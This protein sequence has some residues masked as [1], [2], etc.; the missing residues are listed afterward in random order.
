MSNGLCKRCPDRSWSTDWYFRSKGWHWCP[1]AQDMIHV[2]WGCGKRR[3]AIKPKRI[4]L[5][6]R[7]G[8][9]P[10]DQGEYLT[11]RRRW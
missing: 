9:K 11:E 5:A 3:E 2:S 10:N 8:L 4:P 1:V 7:L 6:V